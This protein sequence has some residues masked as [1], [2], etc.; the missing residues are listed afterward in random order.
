[1]PV[2][3]K[4]IAKNTMFLY[5]R[6]LL[7][8]AITFYTLRIILNILGAE[9]YGIYNVVGGIV[10][11]LSF[12]QSAMM[13]ALQRFISYELGCGTE[14][15]VNRAFKG[16]LS[17]T[18]IFIILILLI[19]ESGGLWAVN[20]FLKI[21]ES[22]ILSANIVYQ[23]SIVTFI[24]G[25]LRIPY[26]AMIISYEKMSFFSVI[27][28]I[29]GGM[30]L[31]TAILLQYVFA[32]KLVLYAVM[33]ALV[34]IIVSFCYYVYCRNKFSTTSYN[35]FWEKSHLRKILSFSSFSM[36]ISVSNVISQ[37]GGNILLNYFSSLIANAALGIANQVGAAI[38]SFSSSFQTAFNPQ[39]I[40]LYANKDY[41][42]LFP[43]VIRASLYSYILILVLAAPVITHM[44]WGLELWL[45]KVPKYTIPFC[46]WILIY[47][48]IDALQ[49]PLNTM[50][51]ACGDIKWYSVWL[52]VLLLLNLPFSALMLYWGYSPITVLIIRVIINLISA[53]ARTDYVK[54]KMEFP[55]R[56]YG[57]ILAFKLIPVTIIC[58]LGCYIIK[59]IDCQIH[60]IIQ[61]IFCLLF[62]CLISFYL[63]VFR[64]DRIKVLNFIKTRIH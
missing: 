24:V 18:F 35:W 38:L 60:E 61:I 22:K 44:G 47:Q 28:I 51:Y 39:I 41:K 10:V 53:I 57:K 63:G 48:M 45:D 56:Q 9:D 49:A 1:M 21:P 58:F 2:E 62:C 40:K 5:V 11:F 16:G 37:Q 19:L 17:I 55:L 23:L 46:I 3:S 29:E 27:S 6:M 36:G 30:R 20:N 34:A 4:K 54:L 32:N 13:T 52:S 14:G 59:I 26:Q 7:L 42:C 15:T 25:L 31:L 33:M 12:I 8:M 43:F 50:V 64:D